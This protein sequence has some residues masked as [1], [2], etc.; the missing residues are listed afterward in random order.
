MM[1]NPIQVAW[2]KGC[3]CF[4][5]CFFPATRFVL[6]SFLIYVF[7]GRGART[8]RKLYPGGLDFASGRRILYAFGDEG[9]SLFARACG[10]M[11][12]ITAFEAVVGGSNP[13][14][15]TLCPHVLTPL[16]AP[17]FFYIM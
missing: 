1:P 5:G 9:S 12:I 17:V 2:C 3:L 8:Q 11:D 6:R 4:L 13:S 15:R 16:H 10:E 14:G 7:Y